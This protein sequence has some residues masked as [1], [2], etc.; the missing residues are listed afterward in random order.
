MGS[1]LAAAPGRV[2]VRARVRVGARAR[3]RARARVRVKVRPALNWE[4]K[5]GSSVQKRRMSGMEKSTIASRSRPRP[6][7]QPGQE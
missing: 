1:G 3:A 5:R 2:R 7:A 4:A 6:N